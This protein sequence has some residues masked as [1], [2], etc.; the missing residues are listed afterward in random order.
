MAE[1]AKLFSA[2]MADKMSQKN[3]S[4][5]HDYRGEYS[6]KWQYILAILELAAI[7]SNPSLARRQ[8][9]LLLLHLTF[10]TSTFNQQEI[11]KPLLHLLWPQIW[12]PDQVSPGVLADQSLHRSQAVDS[13][14]TESD[15]AE[16]WLKSFGVRLNAPSGTSLGSVLVTTVGGS[17]QETMS[18][19]RE[20]KFRLAGDS[21]HN[22]YFKIS[23]TSGE[24]FTNFGLD[25]PEARALLTSL[26]YPMDSTFASL[27]PSLP[28][29]CRRAQRCKLPSSETVNLPYACLRI[30]VTLMSEGILEWVAPIVLLLPPYLPTMERGASKILR[31]VFFR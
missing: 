29:R 5:A 22:Q 24:L 25:R 9:G 18:P 4:E 3:S 8:T 19:K 31:F 10:Y 14:I 2:G 15:H 21:A 30:N 1:F 28:E 20:V 11:A 23:E 16:K 7:D 17:A 27:E 13:P 6:R 12:Q 26:L